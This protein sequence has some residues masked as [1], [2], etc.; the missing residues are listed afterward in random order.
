[1][2]SKYILYQVATAVLST[3]ARATPTVVATAILSGY[4][5][6]KLDKYCN[7][8]TL[9]HYSI[10]ESKSLSRYLPELEFSHG[11][12]NLPRK[13]EVFVILGTHT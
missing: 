2:F 8:H 13:P 9:L 6:T 7:G 5:Y 3:V 1:M 11:N 12:L 10:P 4:I